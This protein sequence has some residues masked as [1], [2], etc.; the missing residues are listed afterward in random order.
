MGS[1]PIL[2]ALK[3]PILD[4]FLFFDK[5]GTESELFGIKRYSF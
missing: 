2:S 5:R 1:N 3:D 4:P